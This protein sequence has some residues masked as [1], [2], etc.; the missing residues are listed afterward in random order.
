MVKKPFCPKDFGHP[1]R[2]LKNGT[3]MSKFIKLI[4]WMNILRFFF[5]HFINANFLKFIV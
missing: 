5:V 2:E 4:D 1:P 3:I